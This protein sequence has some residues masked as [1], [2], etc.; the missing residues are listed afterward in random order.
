MH[1]AK[2]KIFLS[3]VQ[4]EFQKERMTLKD[5][6]EGNDL[7]KKF[8]E[9]FLFENLPASD[10]R[11][12]EAYLEELD[13]S[14]VY[15]GLFG[16]EYGYEDKEGLSP[17]EREF[18]H[19]TAKKKSRL[20]YVTRTD[21][22]T[23]HPK[24]LKLIH[25][26]DSQLIRRRFNDLPELQEALYASLV[27]Y[28]DR[29]GRLRTLPFDASACPKAS[30]SD[31]SPKTIRWFLGKAKEERNY[32][33]SEKTKPVEALA[34]LNLLDG[35]HPT[36][37][38][39]LLFCDNPQRFLPTAEVK[40]LHF[41]GT[42]IKKPIPSYQIYQGNLFHQV[43]QAVDFVMSNLTRAVG[44]RAQG[45]EAP[46][47]Y[48]LP[49]KAVAEAIVNAV[50]HR[51]YTSKAAVQ[52]MLF[53]D[54]LEV[55]NPGELPPDLTLESLRE[56]HTSIPRNPMIADPLF[57]T[58][59]IEKAGTGTLDM[60]ALCREAGLP[61]PEFRQ[62]GR[63]FVVTIWRDW[64]TDV[65]LGE[66]GLNQRQIQATNYLKA[67]YQIT[68]SEYQDLMEVNRKTAARDLTHLVNK[69]VLKRLGAG[70]GVFYKLG[71]KRDKNGTNGT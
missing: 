2:I 57:L 9:V 26:A 33:L 36:H 27:E 30:L 32:S 67:R 46:V 25:L 4:K 18:K 29:T 20:I 24:M 45:P 34:H 40:C 51:D 62:D 22:K 65:V 5:F 50:A 48:E 14:D 35:K 49:K 52:V 12:E 43:D 6:I 63:Q 31:I 53:S 42:E 37:A 1:G 68:N 71:R 60:I 28:L 17:T 69:G 44:T 15:V 7:L 19:A 38:A 70:R 59:Y 41:H 61:E 21:D 47:K 39:I 13:R 64:L 8:F 3:S 54:R 10:R 58:H 23:R 66:M 16:Q 56:P 55:W 11:P